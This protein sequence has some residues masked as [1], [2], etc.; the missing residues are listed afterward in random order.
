M[1]EE[2]I[3]VCDTEN[4]LKKTQENAEGGEVGPNMHCP[5]LN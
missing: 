1:G 3:G 5:E 4:S 2:F